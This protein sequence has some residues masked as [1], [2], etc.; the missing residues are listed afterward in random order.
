MR[1]LTTVVIAVLFLLSAV[2]IPAAADH[3]DG[4]YELPATDQWTTG[5]LTVAIVPPAHGQL[6]NQ[7][8]VLNG[9]D[10]N[11]A[12]PFNSYLRAIEASIAEWNRGIR[13]FGSKRLKRTFRADVYVLGRDDIPSQAS[14]DIIVTTDENKGPVLGFALATEP[15]IVNNSMMLTMSFTYADMFNVNAQEYGHCLG[16]GH[17]GR[18]GAVDPASD[19][20]HPEHDVMNGFYAHDVGGRGNHLHCVSNLDVEGLEYVFGSLTG[21]RRDVVV[22]MHVNRYRTTCGGE[23]RAAP[24]GGAR[25]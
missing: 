3:D 8:G 7:E 12:T 22:R 21:S 10:P 16:L 23:G 9:A 17:V 1:K 4:W 6:A 2:A 24:S 18:Q 19:R 5:R 20:K 13:R 25:R 14:P 15:C 11:E